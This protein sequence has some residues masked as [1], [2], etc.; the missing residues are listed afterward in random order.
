MFT[1]AHRLV[2]IGQRMGLVCVVFALAATAPLRSS[3]AAM[4]R[5]DLQH[6][7]VYDARGVP[8][9]HG[10]KWTF[11]TGGRVYS[12]PAVADGMVFVGSADGNLY[13][14]D[15]VAGTQKWKF[16][17]RGRVVSSPAVEAGVV[18]F[19]SYDSNFYAVD[20][21]TGTLKWKFATKGEKRF[22]AKHIHGMQPESE[23]MP[24]PFD[25]YLSSPAVSNGTVYFGSG[26]GNVYALDAAAG[27][28]KWKFQT[29]DVVHA[30]P[31]LADGLLFIGSWD[32]FFYALDAATGAERW[33][34]KTGDDPAIHNQIGIQSSAAVANGVVYFGC[35]DSKLYAL[36]ARTGEKKW[37]LDN[38]G[39]WVIGSPAIKDG[40]VYFSTADTGLFYGVDARTGAELFALRF[41]WPMF[42]SP[43]I[44]GNIAYLGSHQGK[45]L[46]IDVAAHKSAWT[47]ETDASRQNGPA[48]TDANGKPNYAAAMASNFYD[49]IVAGVQK[50]FNV[51]A[52]LSSPTI[53]GDTLYVGSADGNLYAIS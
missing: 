34:F 13:A 53:A 21:A 45:L 19:E 36:D 49:D 9:L 37:A 25:F 30:S 14:V 52:I 48:L 7:G 28:L 1:N 46:A 23:Q 4:F 15:A 12:S 50:M 24:D 27:T 20:S 39:S 18:Y 29:G 11:K 8:D 33:R 6:T 47:F 5:G 32:T 38:K 41:Q 17:T 42:S 26:D 22:A 43:A 10:V 35:R 31:A 51:G 16:A 2:G 40:K 3:G 44:A